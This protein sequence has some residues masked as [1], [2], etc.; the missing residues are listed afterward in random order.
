[1]VLACGLLALV[2]FGLWHHMISREESVVGE[3]CYQHAGCEANREGRG[4]HL[5]IPIKCMFL[6]TQLSY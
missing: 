4:K 2:S 6:M 1:M 5:P 3:P